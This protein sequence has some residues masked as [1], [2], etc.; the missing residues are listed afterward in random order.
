MQSIITLE[1]GSCYR[2]LNRGLNGVL[3]HVQ[4]GVLPNT[5]VREASSLSGEVAQSCC[6]GH[7][8]ANKYVT[9]FSPIFSPV[10]FPVLHRSGVKLALIF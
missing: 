6:Y 8:D 2:I 1:Q 5:P 3:N 7:S 9:S 4:N 10:F